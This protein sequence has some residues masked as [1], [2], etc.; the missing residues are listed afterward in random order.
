IR[1]S[2]GQWLNM[3]DGTDTFGVYNN[4]GTPEGAVAANIGSLATDTT[5]GALYIKTTDTVATGW[6]QVGTGVGNTLDQAYDEGGPGVGRTITVDSGAVQLT[7]SNAADE[8][9]EV[10]NSANGGAALV[11]NTGTGDSFRV[12]DVASDT[13]PFVIDDSGNVGIGTDATSTK[14][15]V[16]HTGFSPIISERTSS[17]T[18]SS[19][20][21][22][23]LYRKTTG[24][25]AAGIGAEIAFR[26]EDDG[27]NL[28]TAGVIA[29]ILT[30]VS[31][32]S[33]EGALIF[34]VVSDSSTIEAMKIQGISGGRA[35]VSFEAGSA[36]AKEGFATQLWDVAG[37]HFE[38]AITGVEYYSPNQ[39]GGIYGTVYRQYFLTSLPSDLT[40]GSNVSGLIDYAVQF[41]YASTGSNRTVAHGV[42]VAFGSS[43]NH[44]RINLSGMSGNGNLSWDNTTY[45]PVQGW[46]DYTK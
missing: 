11:E 16:V 41:T 45:V 22:L 8:T 6:V 12:N 23:E 31:A 19:L 15:H 34:E 7:G 3:A 21:D 36:N 43:D 38:T 46:V 39:H 9:L 24:T 33:E 4:A 20:R 18:G 35:N 29:G 27:G 40:T 13:S 1:T 2:S 17:S 42:A 30:D 37:G 28:E 10:T 5:N 32:A 26:V 14:L 44:L 25:A